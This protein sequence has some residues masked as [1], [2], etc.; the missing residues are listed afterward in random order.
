M[1]INGLASGLVMD[2]IH[3]EPVPLWG[4]VVSSAPCIP[5]N[6]IYS[7]RITFP[8]SEELFTSVSY[9]IMNNCSQSWVNCT[10][11]YKEL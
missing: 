2:I 9:L 11:E 7:Q 4:R 3:M 5:Q 10:I 8:W 6:H 1:N